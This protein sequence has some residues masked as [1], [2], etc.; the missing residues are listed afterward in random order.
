MDKYDK[1]IKKLQEYEEGC[2]PRG[3]EGDCV[4]EGC[5]HS[6]SN[7]K[8]SSVGKE[9]ISEEKKDEVNKSQSKFK[10]DHDRPNCIGCGACAA[11]Q[12]SL[13]EMDQDGKSN[14]VAGKKLAN[15]CEEKDFDESDHEAH[16][17]AAEA[18]P[19]NVIHIINNETGDKEI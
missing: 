4:S 1:V 16:K 10:I 6:H 7:D 5:G 9:E 13:W 18:C 14:I 8:L 17:E 19:V 12:P 15:G 11:L 3:F 2:P